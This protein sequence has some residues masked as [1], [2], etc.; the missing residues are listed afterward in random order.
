MGLTVEA[1]AVSMLAFRMRPLGERR[2]A[3]LQEWKVGGEVCEERRCEQCNG[4]I[5]RAR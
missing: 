1:A 3:R 5:C 4:D 2:R